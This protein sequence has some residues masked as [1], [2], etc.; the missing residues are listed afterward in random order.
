MFIS[1]ASGDLVDCEIDYNIYY[2]NNVNGSDHFAKVDGAWLTF[3]QWQALGFD[4][5]SI[6]LTAGQYAGLFTD[7]SNGDFTLKIGSVAIGAGVDL[8]ASYDDGLDA[9]TDWG[10]SSTVPVIV[11]KQQGASWDIG[12]YVH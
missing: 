9:S 8:G 3:A 6:Y 5:H 2:K 11:T 12:A 10:D 7:P 1:A 4:A